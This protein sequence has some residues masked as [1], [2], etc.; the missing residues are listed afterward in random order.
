MN[1]IVKSHEPDRILLCMTDILRS[2]FE[3]EIGHGR[4]HVMV[5]HALERR[6]RRECEVQ[7][8]AGQ[9]S[10]R[11]RRQATSGKNNDRAASH[12]SKT[13]TFFLGCG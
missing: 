7:V 13:R 10:V 3:G 4:R 9:D 5:S 11:S 12:P 8:N 1:L 6:R 2:D